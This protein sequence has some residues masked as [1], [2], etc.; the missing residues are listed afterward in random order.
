MRFGLI[1]TFRQLARLSDEPNLA[2]ALARVGLAPGSVDHGTAAPG[3]ALVV[4]EYGMFRSPDRQAYFAIT[5]YPHL[6]AGP[7]VLYR[8][9]EEGVTIDLPQLPTIV[10][11]PDRRAVEHAIAEGTIR[12]PHMGVGD[13]VIWRWPA[14]RPSQAALDRMVARMNAPGV[15][16]T[17]KSRPKK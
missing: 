7:A 17:V 9:D 16:T 15:S 6:C 2:A 12:R 11:M 3:L 13:D 14:P 8:Y 5:G 1:H 4:H 10:W